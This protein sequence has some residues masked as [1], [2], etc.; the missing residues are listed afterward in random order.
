MR[1]LIRSNLE[2]HNSALKALVLAPSVYFDKNPI[3]RILNRFSKDI[4]VVDGPLQ[5]YIY[6]SVSITLLVL[7]NMITIIIILPL[8]IAIFPVVIFI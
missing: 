4:G 8:N 6:D 2:L 3:G 5:F 1:K 7:G